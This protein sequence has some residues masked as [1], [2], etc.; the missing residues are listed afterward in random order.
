V[1]VSLIL[2]APFVPKF[3]AF[4][5]VLN[6]PVS[7][8]PLKV[9]LGLLTLP[10]PTAT[11]PAKVAAPLSDTSKDKTGVVTPPS[12]P[13]ILISPSDISFTMLKVLPEL[14]YPIYAFLEP[15]L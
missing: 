7:V 2:S 13:T 10:S 15:P 11:L 9:I 4:D 12:F 5:A 3:I 1:F 6:I 8:S 14:S